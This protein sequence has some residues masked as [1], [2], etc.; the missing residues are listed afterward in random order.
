MFGLVGLAVS[1]AVVLIMAH[2]PDPRTACELARE[3]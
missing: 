2:P 1:T 3:T